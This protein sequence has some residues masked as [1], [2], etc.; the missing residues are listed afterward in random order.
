MQYIFK[1]ALEIGFPWLSVHSTAMTDDLLHSLPEPFAASDLTLD[2]IQETIFPSSSSN[3]NVTNGDEDQFK[4]DNS[5]FNSYQDTIILR[6]KILLLGDAATGKT[7][8]VQTLLDFTNGSGGGTRRDHQNQDSYQM[9]KGLEM[10][11]ATLLLHNSREENMNSGSGTPKNFQVD[12]F[13]YEMGG[14]S[15]F[16]SHAKAKD[17]N[18]ISTGTNAINTKMDQVML[19]HCSCVMFVFD[20]SSRK[21]LQNV[22]QWMDMMMQLNGQRDDIPMILVGTKVD[23]RQVSDHVILLLMH[24]PP[25]LHISQS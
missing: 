11:V 16:H 12:L 18:R 4:R 6:E 8:L 2:E 23:L 9:T 21:S 14:Q 7:S 10:N 24:A 13:L 15:I 5:N 19:K 1:F 17:G 3:R 20:V 22:I 25:P